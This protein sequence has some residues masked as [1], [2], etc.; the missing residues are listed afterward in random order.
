MSVPVKVIMYSTRFCP[1]CM[2]AR[3]LLKSKGVEF[4]EIA[5]GGKN[6]LWAEM[7]QRSGRNTVPQIFINDESVGGFDDIAAL[8]R[9]GELDK[10]LGIQDNG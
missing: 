7:E 1:Y 2:R 10:K 5:V 9:Q 6:E 3:R 8:N 4:T